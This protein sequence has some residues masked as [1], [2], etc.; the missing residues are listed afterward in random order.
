MNGVR[1][2][3]VFHPD[4]S[5]TRHVEMDDGVGYTYTLTREQWQKRSAEEHQGLRPGWQNEMQQDEAA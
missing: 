1:C 5:V 2:W 3:Q 4:G